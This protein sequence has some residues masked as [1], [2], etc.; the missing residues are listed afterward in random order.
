MN[1][2]LMGMAGYEYVYGN[3]LP[4]YDFSSHKDKWGTKKSFSVWDK[5]IATKVPVNEFISNS[6]AVAKH[7]KFNVGI[8][9]AICSQ[10]IAASV[11]ELYTQFGNPES[12][13]NYLEMQQATVVAWRLLYEGAGLSGFSA[14]ASKLL[15][16]LTYA[17]FSWTDCR[18][19]RLGGEY[20]FNFMKNTENVE[21]IKDLD[22]TK[23]IRA[24]LTELGAAEI[25]TEVIYRLVKSRA[26]CATYRKIEN[27]G[28]NKV[29]KVME[30]LIPAAIISG[31]LRRLGQGQDPD[32][33]NKFMEDQN[34]RGPEDAVAESLM[35]LFQQCDYGNVLACPAIASLANV[36][37]R[38]HVAVNTE[39][40]SFLQEQ[41]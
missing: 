17:A 38:M 3:N 6:E 9:Y 37:T 26:I 8:T 15:S 30:S 4:Y 18:I 10:L 24:C 7:Y 21:S 28:V 29:A 14:N 36:G 5:A 32:A 25:S 11:D 22:G 35:D 39:L 13:K 27:E 20:T 19:Q 34:S 16:V 1:T 12:A 2:A 33:V 31:C 23:V 40:A 41:N